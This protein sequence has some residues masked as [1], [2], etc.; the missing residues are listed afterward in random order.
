MQ[1]KNEKEGGLAK[2][3]SA[4]EP[5]RPTNPQEDAEQD[6]EQLDNPPQAEGPR[7]REDGEKQ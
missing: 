2:E 1:E 4:S 3:G 5:V 6:I 7:G